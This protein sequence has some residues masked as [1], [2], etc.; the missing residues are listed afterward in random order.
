MSTPESAL[1]RPF[2]M[3]KNVYLRPLE[4]TDVEGPYLEWL[5][6]HEVTRFLD[7]GVTPTTPASLRRYVETVAQAPGTVMLAIVD[8]ATD[9][10]IGNIKL[11]H[12]HP[13]HRRAD[14]GLMVGDKAFWGRGYGREALELI[15]EYGFERLNLNKIYLGVDVEHSGAVKMYERVGFVVDGTQ[16]QHLFREGAYRDAHVMSILRDDYR[17]GR[18]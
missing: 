9:A 8:K 14:M 2:L 1:R 18:A 11:A 6:D 3:G 12:I 5:N 4:V 15:L 13:V 17:K 16:R 10:H 7:G